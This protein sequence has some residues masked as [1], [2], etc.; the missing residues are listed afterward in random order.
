MMIKSKRFVIGSLPLIV[1]I[2][3]ILWQSSSFPVVAFSVKPFDG[4]STAVATAKE[5]LIQLLHESDDENIA[6]SPLL[7]APLA[8]LEKSY[9]ETG[10]DARS[11]TLPSFD[12]SCSEIKLPAFPGRLGF[13]EVGKPLYTLARLTMGGLKTQNENGQ[14]VCAIE[15]TRQNV[16]QQHARKQ[17]LSWRTP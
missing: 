13:N 4:T 8:E 16:T 11:S 3:A 5:Q 17:L 10:V 12:G 15:K 9:Q 2:S 7:D 14:L 1:F 6:T